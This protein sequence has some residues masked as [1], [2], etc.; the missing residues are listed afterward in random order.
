MNALLKRLTTASRGAWLVRLGVAAFVVGCAAAFFLWRQTPSE[1]AR[2][3]QHYLAREEDR[4]VDTV[5]AVESALEQAVLSATALPQRRMLVLDRDEVSVWLTRRL[6][7]FA[8]RRGHHPPRKIPVLM[9]DG[10]PGDPIV[11]FRF[12]TFEFT[13]VFSVAIDATFDAD[14]TVRLRAGAPRAGRLPITFGFL[15][16]ILSK[17]AASDEI[18]ASIGDLDRHLRGHRFTPRFAFDDTRTVTV[19]G[20][21]I[22]EAEV[23][24]DLEIE[25]AVVGTGVRVSGAGPD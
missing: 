2:F 24:L 11:R 18:R 23:K 6:W 9:F 8:R 15:V 10:A 21:T 3:E 20:V 14:G 13:Q 12:E 25:E 7:T 19:R 16:G 4:H 1:Y 17:N 22:T 5:A